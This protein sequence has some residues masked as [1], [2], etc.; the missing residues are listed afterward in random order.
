MYNVDGTIWKQ[1]IWYRWVPGVIHLR[2]ERSGKIFSTQDDQKYQSLR[3]AFLAIISANECTPA[4]LSRY[5]AIQACATV[6]YVR[7]GAQTEAQTKTQKL[8]EKT[9]EKYEE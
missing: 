3:D 8:D 5:Q 6:A 7:R 9:I 1:R 4:H 2:V